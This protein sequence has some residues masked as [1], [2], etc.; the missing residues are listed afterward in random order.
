MITSCGSTAKTASDLPQKNKDRVK[1]MSSGTGPVFFWWSQIVMNPRHFLEIYLYIYISVVHKNE[2]ETM[3]VEISYV[4]YYVYYTCDLIL[5][6]TNIALENRGW[7][8]TM[9][10][11]LGRLPIIE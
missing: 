10:F 6:Q 4:I 8:T 7:K 1:K 2:I 9:F 3:C 11:L 5:E